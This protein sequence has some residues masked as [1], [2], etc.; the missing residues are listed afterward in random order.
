MDDSCVYHEKHK[1]KK[2]RSCSNL[3]KIGI[4][5][6]ACEGLQDT[7]EDEFE[8]ELSDK[9]HEWGYPIEVSM[10]QGKGVQAGEVRQ[11]CHKKPIDTLKPTS[12]IPLEV[13]LSFYSYLLSLVP[14][15]P[16][17]KSHIYTINIP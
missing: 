1:G 6:K 5:Q 14:L 10:S 3:K 11:R 12:N 13:S 8:S 4:L 15:H 7:Y 2:K 9:E 17:L 16:H